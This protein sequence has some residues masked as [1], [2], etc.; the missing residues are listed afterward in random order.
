MAHMVFIY[1][2]SDFDKTMVALLYYVYYR[3]RELYFLISFVCIPGNATTKDLILTHVTARKR[4]R[5][6]KH[7][8]S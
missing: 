7:T 3:H 4:Q 6:I 2:I 8:L 5:Q 1:I